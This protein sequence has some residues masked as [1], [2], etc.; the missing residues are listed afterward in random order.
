MAPV[1][2]DDGHT[3][4]GTHLHLCVV[5]E[6]GDEV[7]VERRRRRGLHGGNVLPNRWG[8][9]EPAPVAPT[10]PAFLAA[11][12]GARVRPREAM[13]GE[14]KGR[15]TAEGRVEPGGI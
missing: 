2:R 9:G 6:A 4:F 15:R 8:G 12:G 5:V 3:L 10:A 1:P 11:E 7:D 14:A 13:P